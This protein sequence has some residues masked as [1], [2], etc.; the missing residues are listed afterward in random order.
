MRFNR[1]V[2]ILAFSAFLQGVAN[3]QASSGNCWPGYRGDPQLTGVSRSEN[4]PPLKLLWTFKTGDAV[5]SSP[6]I[7]GGLIYTGSNDG[8]LY[9]L[10][11]AGQLKWKFNAGNSIE[12]PV[13]V[14]KGKAQA[15]AP[16]GKKS[17]GG[18]KEVSEIS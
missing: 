18:E 4:T 11:M 2:Y 8:W 9:A 13:L 15:V 1:A 17:A 16:S 5:K 3:A 14:V 6:V 10:T 7:C 12:A